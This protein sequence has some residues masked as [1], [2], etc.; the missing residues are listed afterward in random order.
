LRWA[1]GTSAAASGVRVV[2]L[3]LRPRSR[4]RCTF[5]VVVVNQNIRYFFEMLGTARILKK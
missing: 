3:L 1:R 2:L 5:C 4:D